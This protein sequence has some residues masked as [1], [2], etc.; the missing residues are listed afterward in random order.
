MLC[1]SAQTLSALGSISSSD[2]C[3]RSNACAN[4]GAG[5]RVAANAQ[6]AH[7][8]SA[9]AHAPTE[10]AARNVDRFLIIPGEHRD[11]S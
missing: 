5:A 3:G 1:G 2:D 10:N 7:T 9:A 11:W 8:A 4:D 6:P